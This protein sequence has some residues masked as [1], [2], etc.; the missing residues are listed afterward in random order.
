MRICWPAPNVL[1]IRAC[2]EFRRLLAIFERLQHCDHEGGVAG[3]ERVEE[4][5]ADDRDGVLDLRHAIQDSFDLPDH[6][7]VRAT[8]APSGSWTST[9]KAP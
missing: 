8:E 7:A 9:K 1:A 6:F 3:R 5:V 4:R 2:A